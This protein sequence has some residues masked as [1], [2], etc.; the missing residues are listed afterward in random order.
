[1][2]RHTHEE[3]EQAV[4]DTL[5]ANGGEMVYSDLLTALA[6]YAPHFPLLD[7]MKQRGL[8]KAIVVASD[9]G[10]QHKISLP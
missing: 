2:P 5:T 4:N 8:F 3:F 6:E 7:S 10:P 9:I 1:M